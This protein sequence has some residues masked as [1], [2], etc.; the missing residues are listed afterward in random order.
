V[1]RVK[2]VIDIYRPMGRG[3]RVLNVRYGY[4]L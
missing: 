2:L 4:M 1:L 3:L